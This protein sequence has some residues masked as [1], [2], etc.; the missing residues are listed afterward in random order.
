MCFCLVALFYYRKVSN[1]L[2]VLDEKM[3]MDQ[4][5]LICLFLNLIFLIEIMLRMF[6]ELYIR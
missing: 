2:I 3:Y 6:L 5:K 1:I 4:Y